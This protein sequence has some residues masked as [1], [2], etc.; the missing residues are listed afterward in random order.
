M[1]QASQ[2]FRINF[3]YNYFISF[4]V[5]LIVGPNTW[6]SLSFECWANHIVF[7][8]VLIF[9]YLYL[10]MYVCMYGS[11]DRRSRRKTARYVYCQKRILV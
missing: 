8:F 10:C 1:G 6:G 11:N 9:L 5:F 3:Y 7:V 2:V 4:L